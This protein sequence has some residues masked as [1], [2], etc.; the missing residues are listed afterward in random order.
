[1]IIQG[2]ENYDY[3]SKTEISKE[4]I[5]KLCDSCGDNNSVVVISNYHVV[6]KSNDVYDV[7]P[8]VVYTSLSVESLSD[9][10]GIQKEIAA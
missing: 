9:Y 1:M 2:G 4:E 6:I 3:I 8:D 7:T 10:M 5:S